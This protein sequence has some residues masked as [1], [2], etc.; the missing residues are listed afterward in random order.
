MV[1]LTVVGTLVPY[2]DDSLL[3]A[4]S[5]D[6]NASPFVIAVRNAG[7]SAVPSIMNV[8]ILIA[9]L[10]VGNSSIYGASRTLAALAD[11]GQ[12]PKILGYIDRSGRPLMSIIL[13]SLFGFLAYVVCGGTDAETTAFAWLIALSGLSSIFTWGSICACHIRFRQA[14]KAGGHTLDELAFKSQAGVYGSW[15]GLI[16]NFLVIVVSFWTGFAPIGYADMTTG[17]RTEAWFEANLSLPILIMFYFV[18]KLVRKTK[19]KKISEIDIT[20][21]RRDLDLA[22]I[23]A[24]ERAIQAKWPLWKKVYRTVC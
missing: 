15:V 7:I 18:F 4:S 13:S 8:V 12:A 11:R 14:W 2:D 6:A 21:G 16:F 19:I 9:V 20:S 10:S 17:E 1:S 3:G 23:L 5:S 22:S 24:E